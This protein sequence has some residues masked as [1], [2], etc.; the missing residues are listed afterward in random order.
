LKGAAVFCAPSLHGE[1]FGVVLIEA[2]A[3]RTPV[4]ASALDGY[5]NVATDGVDS[6]LVPP[7]DSAA[8]TAALRSALDDPGVAERLRDAGWRRAQE[9]SMRTLAEL[10]LA[11]YRALV[12]SAPLAGSGG[13]AGRRLRARLVHMLAK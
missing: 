9:F 3:A 10:Y 5:R 4:V 8:L 1:S 6:L 13:G 2:M 12:E 7:G 11:R